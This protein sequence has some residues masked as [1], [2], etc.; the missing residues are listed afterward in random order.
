MVEL[1]LRL[2]ADIPMAVCCIDDAGGW[3][4]ELEVSGIHVSALHR[5]PG[6]R[7]DL[8]RAI[9]RA[10]RHHGA[11]TIHAH[12]Y[13]PFVYS[14][15]ARLWRPSSAV[16]FTEHG[17][18]SD[19]PPSARRRLANRVLGRFPQAV[20]TVSTEL[21]QH[22]LAEG[23]DDRMV[24]VIYNGIDAGSR[25]DDEARSQARQ[26]LGVRE[27]TLVI[28]TIARLD[29]VKDLG[30]L[31][32]AV[33]QLPRDIHATL[34]IIGDGSDRPRLEDEV[35]ALSMTSSVVFLGRRDDA[36]EWLAG[37]DI[38]V[39]SSISEGVSLT[40]LEAMAASLPVVATSVG[41]TPEVVDESCGRLV[42]SRDPRALTAAVADL[43]YDPELRRALGRAARTRVEA[44]FTLD[45]MVREYRDVYLRLAGV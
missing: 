38:Y 26:R 16:V 27:D 6:F 8:G 1:A 12:H 7:P 45:R 23:F 43:W 4:Q 17:R 44:R 19:A 39:N 24:G 2:H 25:P 11:T 30:T 14:C 9:A 37:C 18:L 42:P 41:G 15:L 22:L 32:R 20:F 13:S 28:G 35:R 3:A 21:K 31:V 10:A 36:R 40:I 5:A 29:P 33:G 34:V